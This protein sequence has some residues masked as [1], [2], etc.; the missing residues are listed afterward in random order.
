MSVSSIGVG[1]G[2]DLS[3]LVTQ[4]L[5]AERAPRQKRFD[6]R[7]EELETVIAAIRSLKSKMTEFKDSVDDLRSSYELQGRKAI[8]SHPN[9]SE[10]EAGPFTAEA[11][12]SAVQNKYQITIEQLASGSRLET[13]GYTANGDTTL[14]S[15]SSDA[16]ST[17]AGAMT[18]TIGSDTFNVNVTANMSLANLRAIFFIS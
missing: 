10:D 17:T 5:E 3:G 13:A 6:D 4:L 2:L 8:T 9:S 16:V 7:E 14:F 15:S 18:F 11:S 1:S 12:N